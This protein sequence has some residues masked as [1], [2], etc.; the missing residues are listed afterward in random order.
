[1]RPKYALRARCPLATAKWRTKKGNG[2]LGIYQ[3]LDGITYE[4]DR[5]LKAA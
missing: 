4:L 5:T 1:M 3:L 2:L